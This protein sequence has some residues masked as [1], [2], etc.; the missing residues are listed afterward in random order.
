ML[1]EVS[2]WLWEK[3]ISVGITVDGN[4]VKQVTEFTYLG[5]KITSDGRN[6]N[7]ISACKQTAYLAWTCE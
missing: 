2:V 3:K 6:D 7:E 1:K 5:A 4:P